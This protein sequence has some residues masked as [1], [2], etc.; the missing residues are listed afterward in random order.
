MFTNLIFTESINYTQSVYTSLAVSELGQTISSTETA[1]LTSS[2]PLTIYFICV[3]SKSYHTSKCFIVFVFLDNN[4]LLHRT[5]CIH[6]VRSFLIN[7]SLHC[8]SGCGLSIA[9][10]ITDGQC[11]LHYSDVCSVEEEKEVSLWIQEVSW[12][13]QQYSLR[14]LISFLLYKDLQHQVMGCIITNLHCQ[15]YVYV[16]ISADEMLAFVLWLHAGMAILS[17]KEMHHNFMVHASNPAAL[18][19]NDY[20]YV[21][22]VRK[23]NLWGCKLRVLLFIGAYSSCITE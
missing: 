19:D 13:E 15:L 20:Q 10:P 21:V 11:S 2:P 5:K 6:C 14:H 22:H 4:E 12:L 18:E 1:P 8:R 23:D 16:F 3:I 9:A 7:T 17:W